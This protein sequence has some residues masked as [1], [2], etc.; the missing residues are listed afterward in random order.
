[1]GRPEDADETV[2]LAGAVTAGDIPGNIFDDGVVWL[3]RALMPA[4][5]GFVLAK[6][7]TFC[8]KASIKALA[9]N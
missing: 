9:W 3:D 8:F 2:V 1:M 7:G 6:T 5:L 4:K